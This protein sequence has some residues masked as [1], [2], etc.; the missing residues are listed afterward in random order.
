MAAVRKNVGGLKFASEDHNRN[1]IIHS[2]RNEWRFEEASDNLKIY[3]EIVMAVVR[4]NGYGLVF[5]S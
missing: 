5:T 1:R 3:R 2:S 4:H